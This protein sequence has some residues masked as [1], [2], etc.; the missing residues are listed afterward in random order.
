MPNKKAVSKTAKSKPATKK[1]SNPGAKFA[2]RIR[3]TRPEPAAKKQ[4][5]PAEKP[6]TK[7]PAAPAPVAATTAERRGVFFAIVNKHRLAVYEQADHELIPASKCQCRVEYCAGKHTDASGLR[8][9]IVRSKQCPIDDH[10]RF[11]GRA[12]S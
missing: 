1:T 3:D 9:E 6:A 12:A 8:F 4:P 7:K 2:R 10:R 5:A 11:D